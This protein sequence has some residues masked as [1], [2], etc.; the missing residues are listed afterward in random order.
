VNW[1]QA[2]TRSIRSDRLTFK[3]GIL[4]SANA[5]QRL[6][7]LISAIILSRYLSVS[8]YGSYQQL[9]VIYGI[10][11]TVVSFGLPQSINFFLPRSESPGEKKAYVF[12]T[13]LLL[14]ILSL[15]FALALFLSSKFISARFNNADLREL[16]KIF[17]WFILFL[18][19]IQFIDQLLVVLDKTKKLAAYRIS[20]AG[21]RLLSIIV[22]V[23]M[24]AGL[25]AIVISLV[26]FSAVQFI[27]TSFIIFK[28]FL[29]ITLSWRRGFFVEQIKYSFYIGMSSL[30][31]VLTRES[32]KI[33]ISLFFLPESF[34][35]YAN[36][37]REIPFIGIIAGSVIAVLMPELVTLYKQRKIEDFFALWHLS[38]QKV[39][40][41]LF[42]IAVFLFLFAKEFMVTLF[43]L[44]YLS[45]MKVF[46][47]YL[48]LIPLRVTVYGA[49]LMSIGRTSVLFRS[50]VYALLLN[51]FLNILFVRFFG[52]L[53]PAIATVLVT[54]TLTVYLLHHIKKA[55]GISFRGVM[56]WRKLSKLMVICI[57]LIILIAPLKMLSL[58]MPL[59]FLLA[60]VVY[61]IL[62]AFAAFKF[63]LFPT[64]GQRSHVPS[65]VSSGLF[66]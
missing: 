57:L 9:L 65:S 33:I 53:G 25:K 22:P 29:D 52:P 21:L 14:L 37:A 5:S 16:L 7:M 30:V 8:A 43:S 19:P 38:M 6:V 63:Q 50:S 44:K 36:G 10:L 62:Y 39:A 26:A 49:I 64:N 17:A 56:P 48:L 40:V 24:K 35:I 3:A 59:R 2:L 12:Q 46:R 45:S 55:G 51:I 4:A 54:Y 60:G 27:V 66:L 32:D 1:I 61:F 41:V 20:F 18:I 31:G 23:F 42:P 15:I 47:I 34:A 13:Y 58:S 28:L 11:L